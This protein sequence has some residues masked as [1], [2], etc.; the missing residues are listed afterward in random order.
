MEA[1][2]NDSENVQTYQ[3]NRIGQLLFHISN[4]SNR[5][6]SKKKKKKKKKK[7]RKTNKREK[8]KKKKKY[9]IK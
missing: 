2:P 4:W 5:V 6:E 7:P 9:K 1:E 8:K 3:V